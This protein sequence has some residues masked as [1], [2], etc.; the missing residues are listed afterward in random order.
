[1]A[2]DTLISSISVWRPPQPALN[3]VPRQ[4]FIAQVVQAHGGDYPGSVLLAGPTLVNGVGDGIHPVEY[5]YVLDPPFAL[6]S[7]GKYFFAIREATCFATIAVVSDT[8][9]PYPEGS[10]Y[11]LRHDLSCTG[12]GSPLG[13]APPNRDFVFRVDF[14]SAPTPVVPETWGRLKERYR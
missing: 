9:N 2:D 6:P 3:Y 10:I 14:C 13:P 11:Y 12:M 4:L 7:K 8:T 1:V 5:C